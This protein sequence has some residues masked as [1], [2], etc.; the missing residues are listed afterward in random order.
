M[1]FAEGVCK[2][3]GET[4][5]IIVPSC[6]CQDCMTKR[7]QGFLEKV[8][9]NSVPDW[10]KTVSEKAT[11]ALAALA[12]T[13]EIVERLVDNAPEKDLKELRKELVRVITPI[14]GLLSMAEEHSDPEQ[15]LDPECPVAERLR[16]QEAMRY[17]AAT[18][19]PDEPDDA[20]DDILG[21]AA[22]DDSG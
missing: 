17:S 6:I 12:G 8:V 2:Y 7:A 10:K 21:A 15:T 4:K 1:S 22:I 16:A 13:M 19:C 5:T 20:P 18:P 3:C 14:K 9:T 11:T